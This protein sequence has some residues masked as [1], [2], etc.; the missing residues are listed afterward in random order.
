[1]KEQER[2][3]IGTSGWHYDHWRGPF[4]P[5]DLTKEDFLKYYKN[6][7]HTVEINNTFYQLPEKETLLEWRKTV[8]PGFIFSV[9]GSRYITHMK[10]LKDPKK[11]VSTFLRRIEV[12][13]NNLGPILFQLP[14]RWK[15][16]PDRLKSFLEVLPEKFHY[17]FEFR[18]T[19]WFEEE[20]LRILEQHG[21]AFCIYE[22]A[23]TLSPKHVTADFIYIRLHGPKEKAYKGQ[24]ETRVLSGWA[25]AFSA[26][27]RQK[28]EIFC[29]FDNDEAGYAAQDALRLQTM[30]TK[31]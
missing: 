14:P 22:F 3:H 20:T 17:A 10:K 29:Y 16:N 21:A 23:G 30:I 4:Y 11:P 1:M 13:G 2:I 31:G 28:K 12:L 27:T 26:W 7:F 8:P 5:E 25:G 18:D 15:F 19:S 6:Q 24:Y 9:K